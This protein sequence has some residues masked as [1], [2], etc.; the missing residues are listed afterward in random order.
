[1]LMKTERRIDSG[2][3][4]QDS[5]SQCNRQHEEENSGCISK[6]EDSRFQLLSTPCQRRIQ[7]QVRCGEQCS[8]SY[9]LVQPLPDSEVKVGHTVFFFLSAIRLFFTGVGSLLAVTVGGDQERTVDRHARRELSLEEL[10]Q[11][12]VIHCQ[13]LVDDPETGN[14]VHI[15][16]P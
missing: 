7:R 5:P 15:L 9:L 13:L 2:F 14:R 11:S 10:S 6:R 1:M 8:R 3:L 16:H 12:W 4:L